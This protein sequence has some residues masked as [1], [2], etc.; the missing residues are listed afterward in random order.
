[1][2]EAPSWSIQHRGKTAAMHGLV[3]L[4]SRMISFSQVA[5]QRQM[6][7]ARCERQQACNSG[8]MLAG[9]LQ[10]S[11]PYVG[12]FCRP[13]CLGDSAVPCW[14]V[15]TSSRPSEDRHQ[16]QTSAITASKGSSASNGTPKDHAHSGDCQP[17]CRVC[18][19]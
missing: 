14:S 7:I 16:P 8:G 19:P 5:L 3:F 10:S 2:S 6:M 9:M 4:S 17:S 12:A 18:M 13:D 11:H 1:M 15:Q